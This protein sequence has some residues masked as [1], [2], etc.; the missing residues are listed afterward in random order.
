M[1]IRAEHLTVTPVGSTGPVLRDLNFAVERGERILLLGP[2]GAGKSTLLL[3]LSGVLTSLETAQI[4]GLLEVGESGLLLQHYTDATIADT[5]FRDVAFGAESAGLPVAS[6]GGLVETALASVGLGGTGLN[7]NP[8]TLSGG[9]L[10]RLCLAGLLT[11]RP[12]LLLL[13]EPTAQLDAASA[14]EVRVAVEHYV[15]ETGATVILAEHIFEPWLPIVDRVLVLDQTGSLV[16]DGAV[17]EVLIGEGRIPESWGL[18]FEGSVSVQPAAGSGSIRALIGPSGAGKS[19]RLRADLEEK[20]SQSKATT[21]GWL[22][23]SPAISLTEQTVLECLTKVTKLARAQGLLE[24]LDLAD[25]AGSSPHEI[26]GGEQRRLALAVAVAGEPEYLYLDEPTVGLDRHAWQRTAELIL[27]ERARGAQILL[28]THDPHLLRFADETIEVQPIRSA[29]ANTDA[30]PAR[31]SPLGLLAAGFP[32]LIGALQF[33]Y[34]PSALTALG[35]EVLALAVLALFYRPLRKPRLLIPILIGVASAGFTNWWLSDSRS[36]TEAALVAIRVAFF[37]LPGL[38]FAASVSPSV[39]GDQLGQT[40]RLPARPVVAA[41]VGL[42]RI[43]QLQD[44]W[45]NLVLVRRVHGVSQRG[46]REIVA[47]TGHSL[48]AAT[49]SAEVA[50]IAMESRGFSALDSTGKRMRRSWAVPARWGSGDLW[51]ILAAVVV[52]AVGVVWR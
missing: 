27:D 45:Q 14:A 26:S 20:R 48:I 24:R 29:L 19:T 30:P 40:L 41:M 43:W 32:T 34:L 52:A 12:S 28:A 6:I 16:A 46:L 21:T 5:V 44:N 22:P 11:L 4:G 18:W 9:E 23:Q 49:R 38:L 36:V 33:H 17:A 7:R 50:S 39:L 47:L 15:A 2:S 1:Q 25:L 3:A 42:N 37:G 10:Q 35:L 51:L 8:G 31:F 13:D